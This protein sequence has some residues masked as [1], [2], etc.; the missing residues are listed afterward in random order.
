[1]IRLTGTLE[2]LDEALRY[3][4]AMVRLNQTKMRDAVQYILQELRDYARRHAPFRDRTG[5]LRSSIDYE[6]DPAPAASGSLL[7]GTEYAIWVEL[8]EG[9]WVLT[10]AI[11][12][13]RPKLD[14]LFA[15]LIRIEQPDLDAEAARVRAYYRELRGM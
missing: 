14:Q 8:R 4:A 6:M 13:Y 12:F 2:G 3:T 11:D 10:G 9:Y 5:N 7:A 1:M 15:G